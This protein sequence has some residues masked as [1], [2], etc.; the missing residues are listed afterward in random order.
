MRSS[1][2]VYLT[3]SGV[4]STFTVTGSLFSYPATISGT[5]NSAILIEAGGKASITA[6]VT[7]STFTDIVSAATQIGANTAGANGTCR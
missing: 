1:H 7:G 6:S 5:A 3:S 4:N 2:L